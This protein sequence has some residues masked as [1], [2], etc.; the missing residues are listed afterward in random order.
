MYIKNKK[1][2]KATLE[3]ILNLSH[4]Y[5]YFTQYNTYLEVKAMPNLTGSMA[6]P[7]LR[8]RFARFQAATPSRLDSN[9]NTKNKNI[10]VEDLFSSFHGLVVSR[11]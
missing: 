10:D 11:K 9:L 6:M 3:P 2:K 7:R 1:I 4:P 5:F 8:Q